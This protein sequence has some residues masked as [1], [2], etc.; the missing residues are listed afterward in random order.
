MTGYDVPA[1]GHQLH[2]IA[3]LCMS[4]GIHEPI[5]DQPMTVGEAGIM[6]RRLS[7]ERRI[8]SEVRKRHT[9]NKK[10]DL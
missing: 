7:S 10:K 8:K 1:T 9:T 4:A 2:T 5:E 3:I 6:I